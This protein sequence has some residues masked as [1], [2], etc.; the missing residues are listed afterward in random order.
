M[1][2][3]A[4][5]AYNTVVQ[6]ASKIAATGLG[7]V[8]IAVI[9]RYL[10][11]FGF[12]EY[13]VAVTFIGFFA[14]AADLG[15]TL[16]TVQVISRPGVDEGRAMKNLLALRLLSAL[17]FLGIG[18][19]TVFFFPYSPLVKLSVAIVSGAYVFTALNQVLVGLFQKYLRT[20][21]VAVAELAGR[22]VL[23]AGVAVAARLDW[24]LT[25]IMVATVVSGALN[26]TLLFLFARRF[27]PL[28]LSFDREYWR[29]IIKKSWP[30]A[31]TIVFN[32]IY[33]RADTL[34]LSVLPRA[35][36][37]GLTADVGI[38]GAAYRVIDVLITFPFIFAGLVLPVMAAR[39]AQG[40]KDEFRLVCQ[41]A[42]DLMAVLAVP[43][44]VGAQFTARQAMVLVAGDEFAAS[45]PVLRVLV[46]GAVAV[47]LGVALSH[48]VIA[49]ERQKAII[50][51]YAFVALSSLAGYLIFIPRFGL[52]GAAGVTVY[53]EFAIALASGYVV[54]RHSGFVPR[55]AVLG[56]SLAAAAVMAAALYLLGRTAAG[57]L[58]ASLALAIPA[59]FLPLYAL[60]GITKNDL[61]DILGKNQT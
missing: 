37:R 1:S 57:G 13:T 17:A 52:W 12:G 22:L 41:R 43:I 24:G 29:E 60:G 28:G 61:W 14:T 36:A 44:L 59:Y 34:L 51:A 30:L 32:L 15:L 18:I 54:W 50:P 7:L 40:K 21:K 45:G 46:A 4:K 6:F 9:T 38:Y 16:V 27:A 49:I 48:A 33:L 10:G 5:V 53:S 31:L 19:V 20:D 58:W 3:A 55:L 26:F 2:L 35:S 56:R 8:A 39:W 47:F 11:Q 23:V 25:G 42:F